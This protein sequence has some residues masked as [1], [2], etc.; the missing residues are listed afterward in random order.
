MAVFGNSSPVPAGGEGGFI[1]SSY[2]TEHYQLHTW[3]PGD[4]FLRTEFNEN[5]EALD[6]ALAGKIAVGSYTGD[7]EAEQ[8]I[9]LGFTPSAVFVNDD[10]GYVAYHNNSS[11]RYYGG[12]ALKGGPLVISGST[13][14][15]VEEGG[16][17]VYPNGSASVYT[18]ITGSVFY[19]AALR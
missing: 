15:S 11:G 19:Y 6:G 12:M 4:D 16:F 8:F 13:I 5:F 2:L 10:S 9:S 7:G 18:N 14:L 17:R 3:E 1:M